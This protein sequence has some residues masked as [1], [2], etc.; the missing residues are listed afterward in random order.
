MEP[1]TLVIGSQDSGASCAMVV[2]GTNQTAHGDDQRKRTAPP[3]TG[4]S[5]SLGL[6]HHGRR[7]QTRS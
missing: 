7:T 6:L 1:Q 3:A 2:E 5:L 4:H